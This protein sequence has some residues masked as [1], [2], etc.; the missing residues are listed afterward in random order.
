MKII[1]KKLNA[2]NTLSL[3]LQS[4]YKKRL[5]IISMNQKT[6]GDKICV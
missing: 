1:I 2:L 5:C 4:F 6:R 3:N